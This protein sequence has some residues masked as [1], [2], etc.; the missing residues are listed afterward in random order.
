MLNDP[1]CLGHN[2]LDFL[3]DNGSPLYYDVDIEGEVMETHIDS[4]G[5]LGIRIFTH[6]KDGNFKHLFWHLKSFACEPGD[7]VKPGDL[8]GYND[9][10]GL[11]TCP[12]LH[13]GLKPQVLNKFQ[14]WTNEFPNNGFYGAID[15]EPYYKNIFILDHL[16]IV[17]N[18]LAQ[19]SI[20]KKIIELL[21]KLIELLKTKAGDTN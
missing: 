15:P 11:S 3:C 20:R 16:A 8:I 5:G 4:R 21:R 14:N 13:R 10:T 2:G 6:D 19:I 1:T 9:D 17:N 12:H 18:L 7:I